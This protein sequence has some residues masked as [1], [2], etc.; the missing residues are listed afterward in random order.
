VLQNPS[1][2]G[3]IADNDVARLSVA[4]VSTTEGDKT[5]T[6]VNVP[7]TLSNP[8]TSTITVVVTT[9]GGS[10]LA[11]GDFVTKTQTLT[12]NPGVTS[13]NFTVSIVGDKVK[14]S[15][16]TFTVVL[17][18][19]TGGATILNGTGTVTI[20]DNDGA[21]LAAD[22]APSA[23]TVIPLTDAA[24][25]AVVAQA[26]AQW[27]AALPGA[28]LTGVTVAI[29]DLPALQLGWT[30]GRSITID[31]TAAGWGWSISYSGVAA[32]HMDLLTVV[33]HEL[34]R[35]L[36]YTTDDAD[37]I[38]VMQPTLAA[39]ERVALRLPRVTADQLVTVLAETPAPGTTTRAAGL[40]LTIR[41]APASPLGSHLGKTII[42]RAAISKHKFVAK[43]KPV[44]AQ[45]HTSHP[46]PG[47]AFKL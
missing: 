42:V 39:G 6:T 23:G 44:R 33:L 7:V 9:V 43:H 46:H 31:A 35:V 47:K 22:A 14:E 13:L 8:S 19:P 17:S 24:L 36:G 11:G 29:T 32:S 21:M 40:L 4:S 37:R 1:A 38:A 30:V 28:D 34:G 25:A 15:T 20:V 12:F 26:K 18:S 2:S 5:T 27:L 3:S 10:A 45:K 41:P 16:E